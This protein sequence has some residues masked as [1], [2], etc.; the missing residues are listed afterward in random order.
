MC[1]YSAVDGCA[2][3]WHLV[4]G[5]QLLISGAGLFTIEATALTADGQ[6][7]LTTTFDD[8][9]EVREAAAVVGCSAPVFSLRLH[10]ARRRLL[11]E[12]Q[13]SGHQLGQEAEP[14]PLDQRHGTEESR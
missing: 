8:G 4:H 1:Q 6:S 2:T 13:A 12:L 7:L 9:L 11:K 3:D 10:R 14:V 5:G